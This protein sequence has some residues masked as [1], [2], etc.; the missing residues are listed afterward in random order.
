MKTAL[1]A[2]VFIA[3]Y[4]LLALTTAASGVAGRELTG[5]WLGSLMAGPGVQLRL[6][7]EITRTAGGKMEGVLVSMDQRNARIPVSALSV[8]EGVVHL[9]ATSIGAAFDG[10]LNPAGSEIA[11]DWKQGG[12]S[13][14][15]V[16]KRQ[17]QA[18][19][20]SFNRPPEPKQPYPYTEE[21]VVVENKTAGLKLAGTLILPPVSGPHPAVVLI[22]G[23]GP[24]DRDETVFNLSDAMLEGPI[25]EVG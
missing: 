17:A 7:L 1:T 5:H 21:Q 2:S 6:T 12:A 13:L 15:L 19:S 11:G 18:P 22:T 9:E 24:Q 4:L 14:P 20:F 16:F 8:R 23:S 3:I 25:K 10:K